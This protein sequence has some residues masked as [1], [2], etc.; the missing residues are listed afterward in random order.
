[1]KNKTV[2]E[3]IEDVKTTYQEK[4]KTDEMK[5]KLAFL[6]HRQDDVENFNWDYMTMRWPYYSGKKPNQ[7]ELAWKP[8]DLEKLKTKSVYDLLVSDLRD[9][10][11]EQHSKPGQRGWRELWVERDKIYPKLIFTVYKDLEKKECAKPT[12]P[13]K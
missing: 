13:S 6:Q 12:K 11:K 3:L 4:L 7:H 1:M 10:E 2:R 9:Q 5:D 8:S